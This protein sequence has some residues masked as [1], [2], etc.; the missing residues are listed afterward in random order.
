[1]TIYSPDLRERALALYILEN[2][3]IRKIAER[4]LINKS[5]VNEWLKLYREQGNVKPK[6]VG[7]TRKS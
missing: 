1:M 5:T 7:S 6:R 4:L 2:L 3:S